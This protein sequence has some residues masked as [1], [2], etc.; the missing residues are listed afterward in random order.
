MFPYEEAYSVNLPY[1]LTIVNKQ[2]EART[3]L[4]LM[5]SRGDYN[6]LSL[7]WY[8]RQRVVQPRA[9]YGNIAPKGLSLGWPEHVDFYL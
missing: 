6:V 2:H 5:H 1:L 8:L 3:D 9:T 7:F 4:L